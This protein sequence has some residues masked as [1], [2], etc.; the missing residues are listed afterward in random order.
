MRQLLLFFCYIVFLCTVSSYKLQGLKGSSRK[1]ISH[2]TVDKQSI[3]SV[4]RNNPLTLKISRDESSNNNIEYSPVTV[5]SKGDSQL[6]QDEYLED[7]QLDLEQFKATAI[8]LSKAI[9]VGV[10]TGFSIVVFKSSIGATQEILYEGLADF[11]PKPSFYWPLALFPILGSVVVSFLTYVVGPQINNGIDIIAQTIDIQQSKK[12]NEIDVATP[13]D[14]A[15]SAY[16]SA[17]AR[18]TYKDS[19]PTNF[20]TLKVDTGREFR[21]VKLF[22]RL[23]SSVFTL[24]SGC[25][26]G[27]EGPC[28][29]IGTGI[30]RLVSQINISA[31]SSSR[32]SIESRHL[33]LAGTAAGVAGG[34]NAPITGILF[35]LEVGNRYLS[36]NTITL[37]KK[38]NAD[39][40]RADIA[41]IVLAASVSELI[42]GIGLHES[43]ALSILGNSYAMVS[44]FF[45][46]PL[47]LGLGLAAGSI[48]VIFNK[49]R[50]FFAELY[51]GETWGK[52]LPFSKIPL[53]IRPILGMFILLLMPLAGLHFCVGL[54]FVTPLV[55]IFFK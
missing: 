14:V 42:V 18:E 22:W 7:N 33:F 28:V 5:L 32:S 13:G 21:P 3:D 34:F 17:L 44:P 36:K 23:V 15:L 48:S 39:G 16:P 8:F 50:D 9:L 25:S 45:E 38:S 43:Q 55:A 2:L 54:D 29:E 1:R 26:L 46:L 19:V 20:V 53:H 30:S 6:D 41:A 31:S 10:F 11:L 4:A 51:V 35:A 12:S 49:M 52:D 37:Y 40:P 27:P 24:G 47:Y